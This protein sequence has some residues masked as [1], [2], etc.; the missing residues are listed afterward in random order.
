MILRLFKDIFREVE[1][2]DYK[3][4]CVYK[5]YEAFE[6]NFQ[7]NGGCN[8]NS[9]ALTKVTRLLKLFFEVM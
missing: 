4:E 6:R 5:N 1:A 3:C 2:F 9:E 7:R 8:K